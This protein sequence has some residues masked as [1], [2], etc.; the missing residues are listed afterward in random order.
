MNEKSKAFVLDT[1]A[2]ISNPKLLMD[3]ENQLVIIPETT[4]LGL[5]KIRDKEDA[6]DDTKRI[7]V[8]WL[9]DVIGDLMVR[10]DHT[11][12]FKGVKKCFKTENGCYIKFEDIVKGA[13][14]S[15]T[16]LSFMETAQMKDEY[17]NF[18]LV[19]VTT[20]PALMTQAFSRN[21]KFQILQPSRFKY[22]GIREFVI[23]R[24]SFDQID[25]VFQNKQQ[26]QIDFVELPELV[27]KQIADLKEP[28]IINECVCF[29]CCNDTARQI[30][31]I[32]KT[33]KKLDGDAKSDVP[34]FLYFV[35]TENYSLNG[36]KPNREQQIGLALGGDSEITIITISGPAGTGKT[37]LAIEIALMYCGDAKI[38][39][40]IFE[41]TKTK[42]YD[43]GGEQA[44]LAKYV[45]AIF[46]IAKE[47]DKYC[48]NRQYQNGK[49]IQVA[50]SFLRREQNAQDIIDEYEDR[51]VQR[52]K[53]SSKSK[54]AEKGKKQNRFSNKQM[55]QKQTRSDQFKKPLNGFSQINGVDDIEALNDGFWIS[56]TPNVHI[57]SMNS[58]MGETFTNK[59]V[60][61]ID[62]AQLYSS[63][64]LTLLA[65]RLGPG[66]KMI[67]CGD[68]NFQKMF[69]SYIGKSGYGLAIEKLANDEC[70]AH[71]ELS[72]IKRSYTAKFV[73]E[74]MGGFL[75]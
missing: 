40:P 13:K 26:S 50:N 66:A 36:F 43:P 16:T 73:V 9:R 56:P 34:P 65:S 21:I 22:T 54:K 4:L 67:F 3:F 53:F 58:A 19:L 18:D 37:T 41:P 75:N 35:K 5:K 57:G 59:S 42:G 51:V 44:K 25:L 8:F 46:T 38:F 28:L 60:Y 14:T 20:N 30:L 48:E 72:Q 74:R 47:A 45:R 71:I 69:D 70:S 23:D 64:E 39:R 68:N 33:G 1:S 62:E 63:H 32:Y 17:K 24:E 49:V 31:A 52:D 55:S 11:V 10:Q 12:E 61:I 27:K 29:R 2:L 7:S 6:L 15:E